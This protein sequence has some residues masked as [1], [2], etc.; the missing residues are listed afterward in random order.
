[1]GS[2]SIIHVLSFIKIDKGI[3]AILKFCLSNLNDCNVGITDEEIYDVHR[4]NGL[5]WHDIRTKFYD[6]RLRHLSNIMEITATISEVVMLVL[7][8]EVI[9]EVCR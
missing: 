5:R 8:T 2:G 3:Q 4:S 7:L 9:C 6:D 1:M